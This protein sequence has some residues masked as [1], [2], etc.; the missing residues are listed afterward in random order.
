MLID[1][2]ID[3]GYQYLYSRKHY[4]PVYIWDGTLECADGKILNIYKIEYPYL[5]FGPGRSAKETK[6]NSPEW[7]F[8]T[9]REIKGL[10]F[11]AEVNENT[12]FVLK[13]NSCELKFSAK[14]IFEKGRLDFPIGPKYLN[15]AVIVTKTDYLWFKAPLRENETEYSSYNLGLDVYDWSRMK[16]AWLRPGESA[17]WRYEARES[18]KDYCEILMHLVAM[19]VPEYDPVQETPVRGII[20]FELYCDGEKILGFKR[21]YREHDQFMQ[22]L[23][24]DW[25]RFCITPGKHL[26]ELKNMHNE[27]CL[28]ISRITM[29]PC[30]YNHGELSIP[31]WALKNEEVIGKIFAV[32][33]DEIRIC[34]LDITVECQPGWNEFRF[35]VKENGNFEL[36]TEKSNAKI[37]VFDCEEEWIPVKVGYDMTTVPHDNNGYMDWLLDYTYRTRLGNYVLFRNFNMPI[38]HISEYKRYGNFCRE[39]KIYTSICREQMYADLRSSARE[40]FNDCGTH[41]FPGKVYAFD[42]TEPYSS[43][44]MKEASEK[45]I[46]YLKEEIDKTHTVSDCVAFGDASCGIR[47][48]FL[49]GA[50]FV[51]AE[52]MVG[53]T[54]PLLSHTRAAAEALGKGRWGVHI[55]IQHGCVPYHENHLSQY[56][57]SLMQPWIMGAELIYEE[58]SLFNLFKE[59]RQAWDDFLTKEKRDMTRRFYKFVKTHPR[60]G[61]NIRNIAYLEGR[62]AAPFN[63]FIC[64]CEQDPDYS[65]WGSFGNSEK[66]WGHR[67]PEKAHQVLDVLM[68]GTSTHPL[69]QK[70]DK[71][72]FYF[73]GSPYGDFDSVPIEADTD[74]FKNYK[75]VLNLGWNTATKED[76]EKLKAFVENGG[77][78]LTGIPQFSTHVKRK[79]LKE[80]QELLLI[81]KG[82]LSDFCGIRVKGRGI[83]YSGVW[84]TINREKMSEPELSSLPSRCSEE[85]GKGFLADV[86]LCGAEVVAW[87]ACTGKPM[88]VKYNL[89]KGYVFTFTIWAYPGHEKFQRFSASWVAKLAE[90]ALGDVYAKDETGEVFWTLWENHG[91][92]TLMLLNTDWTS[93]GNVKKAEVHAGNKSIEVDVPES[94]LVVV[95]VEDGFFVRNYKLEQS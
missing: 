13:T 35:N 18:K 67:Q 93:K 37:E 2:R 43:Q 52:T 62:Y 57:L 74:Y 84:N 63:G 95:D 27:F 56:F 50:D 40:M 6:L 9:K 85:D 79:F 12:E 5:W 59:E 92:K 39:H 70:F 32:R 90:N 71:R 91:K 81:N 75:L 58:D 69:R 66:E 60:E 88:L 14:D 31:E 72:R 65:V 54:M 4:H 29:K 55:A 64:D 22:I 53:P 38:S 28:G 10:R 24:D 49:A 16:L 78:L 1:F 48:S 68:P 46:A 11:E 21:F 80:M 8:T 26:F 51:R 47:Y 3:F 42:P 61:K 77:T 45:Y 34:G 36:S 19:A 20:P 25:K 33:G 87:D 86:E 73:S 89:G 83:E 17:K 82:D 44:T 15:C 30:E 7:Q 41:E 94:N 76:Y 23:E